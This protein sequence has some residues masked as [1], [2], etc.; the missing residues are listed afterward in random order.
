MVTSRDRIVPAVSLVYIYKQR[1]L[2]IMR[3]QH[4]KART[5]ATRQKQNAR[6]K[7]DHLVK[8]MPVKNMA[9]EDQTPRRPV[10]DELYERNDAA[11]ELPSFDDL[12][13]YSGK[14]EGFGQLPV[15]LLDEVFSYIFHFSSSQ[16]TLYACGFVSR[17]W[18]R[19]SANF[20]YHSPSISGRNFDQFVRTIC[21]S[22]NAHVRTNGLSEMVRTL[23]MSRLVHNGSRSLTGR[24]LGRLKASLEDFVAPQASFAFVP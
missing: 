19:A 16:S 9:F 10:G 18:Y 3:N 20:L 5:L 8:E 11:G 4:P 23:D 21:P 15:E 7:P 22:V 2:G 6:A 24:L 1:E 12:S 13:L 14:P 17:S